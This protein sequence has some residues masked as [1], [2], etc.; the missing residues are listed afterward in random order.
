MKPVNFIVFL[1]PLLASSAEAGFFAKLIDKKTP[2]PE[3]NTPSTKASSPLLT[4][5]TNGFNE[6][7]DN[8]SSKLGNV[9]FP[10]KPLNVPNL[11]IAEKLSNGLSMIRGKNSLETGTSAAI[12]NIKGILGS[13]F[14]EKA[15]DENVTFSF[16]RQNLCSQYT[17]AGQFQK[18]L[19]Q[20]ASEAEPPNQANNDANNY[21]PRWK[22]ID[23]LNCPKASGFIATGFHS[24][25]ISSPVLLEELKNFKDRFHIGSLQ[26]DRDKS[27]IACTTSLADLLRDTANICTNETCTKEELKALKTKILESS[28][29]NGYYMKTQIDELFSILVSQNNISKADLIEKLKRILFKSIDL[30]ETIEKD[31][32]KTWELDKEMARSKL[33]LIINKDESGKK[34]QT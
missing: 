9:Q 16:V 20:A 25:S 2:P 10:S 21:N 28:H 30:L 3:G 33:E 23:L 17:N 24:A 13:D 26:I 6:M 4:K 29:C 18:A 5:I 11:G 19:V 27:F 32:L 7:H 8:I 1:F 31:S 15:P 12:A 34:N 14:N 22:I